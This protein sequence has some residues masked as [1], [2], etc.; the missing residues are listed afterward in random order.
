MYDDFDLAPAPFLERNI[1]LFQHSIIPAG[2]QNVA[3]KNHIN[4][5]ACRSSETSFKLVW[6]FADFY[7]DIRE[8]KV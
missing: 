6:Q 7:L 8:T 1:P 5:I 4:S 2:K 3:E